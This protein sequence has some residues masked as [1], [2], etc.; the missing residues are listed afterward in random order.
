MVTRRWNSWTAG[1]KVTCEGDPGHG[2]RFIEDN[3]GDKL[4]YVIDCFLDYRRAEKERLDANPHFTLGDVTT[5]N[6]TQVQ[7]RFLSFFLFLQSTLAS[8]RLALR[9]AFLEE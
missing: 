1:I 7:V 6:L 8:A 3:A 5:V 2:S 9:M 4:R